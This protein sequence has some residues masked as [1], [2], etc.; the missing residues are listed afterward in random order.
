LFL[1]CGTLTL[2]VGIIGVVTPILPTTPFLLLS[3]FFFARGS[4][5]LHQWL[6]THP[7]LSPPIIDWQ[8]RG[9]IRRKAK[10]WASVV[11][12]INAAFPVVILDVAPMVRWVAGLSMVCVLGFILSRPSE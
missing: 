9:V 2:I 1:I 12:I 8:R 6:M 3:A 7:T 4:E 11:I 5:R 10:I